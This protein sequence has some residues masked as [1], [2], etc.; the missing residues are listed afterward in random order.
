MIM[1]QLLNYIS[2]LIQ[3]SSTTSACLAGKAGL[4]QDLLD[5]WLIDP[6]Y[7]TADDMLMYR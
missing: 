4:L 3:E 2:D 6:K 7:K 1:G 5:D